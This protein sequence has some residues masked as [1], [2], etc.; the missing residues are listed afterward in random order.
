MIKKN[1]IGN[2]EAFKK[3]RQEKKNNR[4]N[5]YFQNH[6]NVPLP[7]D[8]IEPPTPISKLVEFEDFR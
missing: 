4:M 3:S 2:Q 1:P 8:L 7:N 5:L 6:G